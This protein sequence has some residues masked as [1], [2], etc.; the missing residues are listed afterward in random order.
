MQVSI[1]VTQASAVRAG[2]VEF[3]ESSVEIV[4]WEGWTDAEREV[5]AQLVGGTSQSV[6]R[7]GESSSVDRH[8]TA[9]DVPAPTVEALRAVVA[10]ADAK[11]AAL[12]LERGAKA[13]EAE[14]IHAERLAALPELARA[15]VAAEGPGWLV[16]YYGE[17]VTVEHLGR[18]KTYQPR[19]PATWLK[20]QQ[21][22]DDHV[23]ASSDAHKASAACDAV[24]CELP[25]DL[26]AIAEAEATRLNAVTHA[27][28]LGDIEK[29]G[30]AEWLRA[31]EG[32]LAEQQKA[33][34]AVEEREL[35][36]GFA[37]TEQTLR[38]AEGFLSDQERAQTVR[39]DIFGGK[40][41]E[42]PR[43]QK[44]TRDAIEHDDDFCSGK[45]SWNVTDLAS[46]T[47]GQFTVYTT[48]RDALLA[49]CKEQGLGWSFSVKPK[50]H[51][52][53]CEGCDRSTGGVGILAT[54]TTPK[55]NEYSREFAT[56]D[57]AE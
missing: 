7:A 33:A 14:R 23:T 5:L 47:A 2:L 27:R 3:G 48:V 49:F 16:N 18:A 28:L 1:Y 34:R 43:Y 6:Y 20:W 31:E 46:M 11:L 15:V 38:A 10:R 19:V 25:D 50:E 4:S 55:V 37:T 21:Y 56:P 42:L 41:A 51:T 22:S 12:V 53:V 40:L 57:E 39:D 30:E 17:A 44:L 52:G 29:E 45:V 9:I 13:D 8:G 32:A 36:A 24:F 54:V 35:F 26:R